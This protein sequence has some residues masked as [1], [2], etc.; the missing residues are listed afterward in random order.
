MVPMSKVAGSGCPLGQGRPD[1]TSASENVKCFCGWDEAI[2]I[3][4]GDAVKDSFMSGS[5]SSESCHCPQGCKSDVVHR[6]RSTVTFTNRNSAKGCRNQ[7]S[8]ALLTIPQ[9]YFRNIIELLQC[10]P[11]SAHEIVQEALRESFHEFQ[12]WSAGP[13]RQCI[14]ATRT[15]RPS[16]GCTSTPSAQQ[17]IWTGCQGV[18]PGAGGCGR[19]RR[20][21]AWRRRCFPGRRFWTHLLAHCICA[22]ETNKCECRSFFHAFHCQILGV[23]NM[24][25]T[26]QPHLVSVDEPQFRGLFQ[27]L[28]KAGLIFLLPFLRWTDWSSCAET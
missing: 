26:L 11:T 27:T 15:V 3:R 5:C 13:V 28:G 18:A 23:P 25:P 10:S 19:R 17:A 2:G 1:F 9:M 24:G 7:S 20:A 4:A 21:K 22:R 8:I 14:H 12:F 16:N 6:H